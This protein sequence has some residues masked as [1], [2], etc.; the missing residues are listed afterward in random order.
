M[1]RVAA[2]CRECWH[3]EPSIV[4]FLLSNVLLALWATWFG[5][6][7]AFHFPLCSV[8]NQLLLTLRCNQ[9]ENNVRATYEWNF[10]AI[11]KLHSTHNSSH[12][13][14]KILHQINIL[15]ESDTL[16]FFR[17]FSLHLHLK[18]NSS[19]TPLNYFDFNS[20]GTF[21]VHQRCGI[22]NALEHYFDAILNT[23]TAAH[24]TKRLAD[25]KC[26]G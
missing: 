17:Q 2:Y 21:G 9:N 20:F 11:Y 5:V 14:K 23:Q 7:C 1:V 26:Y 24:I 15:Y 10:N 16:H 4:A 12:C 13:N 19:Y 6:R 25:M 18:H 3:A 8:F 22:I